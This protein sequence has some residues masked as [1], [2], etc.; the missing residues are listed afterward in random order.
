MRSAGNVPLWRRCCCAT[1]SLAD[2]MSCGA[3]DSSL[4]SI[5]HRSPSSCRPLRP[6]RIQ[7]CRDRRRTDGVTALCGPS[8]CG[9]WACRAEALDRGTLA[10]TNRNS[11]DNCCRTLPHSVCHRVVRFATGADAVDGDGDA[12]I[13]TVSV[14]DA[15]VRYCYYCDLY[16]LAF[17]YS[18]RCLPAFFRCSRVDDLLPLPFCVCLFWFDSVYIVSLWFAKSISIAIYS[19]SPFRQ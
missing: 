13:L 17:C 14:D 8:T 15:L 3:F 2:R 4:C 1:I 10:T 18:F 12:S 11:S 16:S 7:W 5:W 19:L 6:Y 9:A